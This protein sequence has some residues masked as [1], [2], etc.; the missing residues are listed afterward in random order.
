MS[1]MLQVLRRETVGQKPAATT[2]ESVV[3]F[4]LAQ[5]HH[6]RDIPAS[7]LADV[8]TMRYRYQRAE[9]VFHDVPIVSIDRVPFPL[10][11]R[12]ILNMRCGYTCGIRDICHREG[13]PD[14]VA[15]RDL[16]LSDLRRLA[17]VREALGLQVAKLI[18]VETTRLS[19]FCEYVREVKTL[20][21]SSVTATCAIGV[22]RR[23]IASLVA[24]GIDR[25]TCSVHQF[26]NDVRNTIDALMMEADQL[27][28]PV[29]L[30][31]VLTQ[32]NVA[33]LSALIEYIGHRKLTARLFSLIRTS[34]L[35]AANNHE[36]LH[37][38]DMADLFSHEIASVRVVDYTVSC[39]RRYLTTLRSGATL[40]LS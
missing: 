18:G 5:S 12:I 37:W 38:T 36:P 14:E 27:E 19:V 30:N 7:D 28:V 29:K 15:C 34:H 17:F 26:T 8:P 24:A 10:I 9:A 20:G 1:T 40:D 32:H 35:A 39:R 22:A 23:S 11:A 6:R 33:D 16:S 25:I 13:L 2:P 21:F 3:D 31:W 4:V